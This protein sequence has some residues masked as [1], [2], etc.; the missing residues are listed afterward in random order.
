MLC[1]KPRSACPT[2]R[3]THKLRRSLKS[4]AEPCL[5]LSY[6]PR[7]SEAGRH[8]TAGVWSAC[9]TQQRPTSLHK[10]PRRVPSIV[11][12]PRSTGRGCRAAVCKKR[13]PH[14][15]AHNTRH[16]ESGPSRYAPIAA[17]RA[18]QLVRW[19][20][21]SGTADRRL[22]REINYRAMCDVTWTGGAA[23]QGLPL[24]T[25]KPCAQRGS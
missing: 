15:S 19:S 25:S 5:A 24:L 17:I 7:A 8:S 14:S 11:L 1:A 18:K 9:P 16:Q 2:V 13:P 10:I 21:S 6:V 4:L 12:H 22:A 20:Q 3:C 23:G